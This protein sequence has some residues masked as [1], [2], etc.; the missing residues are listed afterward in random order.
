MQVCLGMPSLSVSVAKMLKKPQV[1]LHFYSLEEAFFEALQGFKSVTFDHR[2]VTFDP[3]PAEGAWAV[4][5]AFATNLY[6]LRISAY[7]DRLR[8]V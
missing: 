3:G 6:L 5:Y 2:L 8:P 1:L 7:S 4:Y